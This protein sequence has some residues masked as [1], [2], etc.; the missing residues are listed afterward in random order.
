MRT[1]KICIALFIS[2]FIFACATVPARNDG[3]FFTVTYG[4]TVPPA[5]GSEDALELSFVL[6][7]SE[8]VPLGELVRS[9]LYGGLSA[10]DHAAKVT[11]DLKTT[12]RL[13]LEEN[14]EWG[15]DQSWTYDE[16]I[17]TA[18]T[19]PYAVI[20]RAM[21]VYQGGAHGDQTVVPYVFDVETPKKIGLDDIIA[22][23]SRSGFY[24]IMNRELRLYSDAKSELP[25]FPEAPLSSGI[26]FEDTVMPSNFYPAADGLHLQWN[27]A[28]IAAYVFGVIDITLGWDE[29]ANLLSPE[30]AA[31]AAVYQTTPR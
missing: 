31:M 26:Y 6:V 19:G 11:D 3:L 13:T 17:K 12:Y 27:P 1:S 30:G 15:F 20:T 9:F 16:E 4:E 10:E 23:E 14:S 24:G 7:D 21:Y 25:L 29:L 5:E 2:A 22:K 8:K 28:E 18:V